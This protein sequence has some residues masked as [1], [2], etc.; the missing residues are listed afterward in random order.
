M[1]FK[2]LHPGKSC[3]FATAMP[4]AM[5]GQAVNNNYAFAFT[6]VTFRKH[7]PFSVLRV[8]LDTDSGIQ[9]ADR[10]TPAVHTVLRSAESI[11]QEMR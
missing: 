4:V 8:I 7:S 9:C 5:G 2:P 6:A 10:R 3:R 1:H 11:T